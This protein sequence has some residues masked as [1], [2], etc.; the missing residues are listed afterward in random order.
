M[1][2]YVET[3][4][5]I[6]SETCIY[7][8]AALVRLGGLCWRVGL[9]TTNG[10]LYCGHTDRRDDGK[11]VSGVEGRPGFLHR[12]MVLFHDISRLTLS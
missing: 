9:M 6:G 1:E 11:W 5:E 12:C 4:S 7:H 8:E 10:S 2:K 3:S